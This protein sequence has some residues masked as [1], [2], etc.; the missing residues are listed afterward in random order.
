M[1]RTWSFA[2]P[3]T[4]DHFEKKATDKIAIISVYHIISKQKNDLS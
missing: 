2:Q 3:Y 1:D 4:Y